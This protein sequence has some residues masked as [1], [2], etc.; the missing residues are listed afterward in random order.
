MPA[1]CRSGIIS[2]SVFIALILSFLGLSAPLSVFAVSYF[3]VPLYH[4]QEKS[5]AI[6][7]TG[8]TVYLFHSGTSDVRKGIHPNDV[9][10]VHRINPSCEVREVG[11]IRVI[12][13]VG[14]NYIKGEVIEG[15]IRADDIARKGEASCLVI[16]VGICD[17]EK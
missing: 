11:K 16:F 8:D 5:E 7:K 15:E 10:I 12:S 9:L 6:M 14:E 13:Y 1:Y 2:K 4:R 17:H 3:P